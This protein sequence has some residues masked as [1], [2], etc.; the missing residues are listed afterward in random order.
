MIRRMVLEK[1]TIEGKGPV[2]ES[3]FSPEWILSTAEHVKLR[4]N[5]GGP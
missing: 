5:L 2:V 1:P 4:R 3:H